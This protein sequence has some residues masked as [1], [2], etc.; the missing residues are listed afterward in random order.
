MVGMCELVGLL[1]PYEYQILLVSVVNWDSKVCIFEIDACQPISL[2]HQV[3]YQMDSLHFEVL[4][5]D[6][7]IQCF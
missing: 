1:L 4:R 5:F 3:W 2:N 7:N 6:K